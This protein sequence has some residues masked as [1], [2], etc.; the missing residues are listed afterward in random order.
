[1]ECF[2]FGIWEEQAAETAVEAEAKAE[3]QTKAE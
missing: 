3:T 2:Q 1:V